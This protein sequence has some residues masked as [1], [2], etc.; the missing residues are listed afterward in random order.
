[1][2]LAGSVSIDDRGHAILS[3]SAANNS[4]TAVCF[5]HWFPDRISVIDVT[6]ADMFVVRDA[7]GKD[8]Q[9][10]SRIANVDTDSANRQIFMLRKTETADARIDLSSLYALGTGSYSVSYFFSTLPCSKYAESDSFLTSPG[11]LKYL[12]DVARSD[13]LKAIAIILQI[14]RNEDIVFLE[15]VRF[16]VP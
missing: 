15:P 2:Q 13:G 16:E 14:S 8:V 5:E 10:I 1:M 4:D 11:N 9:Y 3:L 7:E 12:T 6:Y